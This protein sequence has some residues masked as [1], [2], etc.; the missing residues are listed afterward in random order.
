MARTTGFSSTRKAA[1]AGA[2][3]VTWAPSEID[4]AGVIA[5][6]IGWEEDD[7]S[8]TVFGP[9]NRASRVRVKAGSRTVVDCTVPQLQAYHERFA[10]SRAADSLGT[11][12]AV[13]VTGRVL[14]IPLNGLD[15]STDDAADVVQFMAGATAQVEV[16]I[17]AVAVSTGALWLAWTKTTVPP[18]FYKTILSSP[19]N[20]PASANSFRVPLS[21]EGIVQS[22][23][24]TVANIAQL[25]IRLAGYEVLDM[26]GQVYGGFTALSENPDM[27]QGIQGLYDGVGQVAEQWIKLAQGLPANP[28]NSWLEVTSGAG[29]TAATEYVLESLAQN[30]PG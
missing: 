14:T 27:L 11:V 23:G 13:G 7:T 9:N 16:D 21:S 19:M 12:V 3:T 24:I 25:K 29:M 17:P 10:P 4:S 5:Y 6:H 18:M 1:T 28:G 30:P 15:A 22:L 8:T 20:C 2:S 26:M